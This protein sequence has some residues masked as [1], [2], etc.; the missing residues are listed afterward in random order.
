MELDLEQLNELIAVVDSG[1]VSAAAR[2]L[3]VP[4]STLSRRLT[5]LEA[6]LEVRLLHRKSRSLALTEAGELL[7]SRAR[8]L[9]DEAQETWRAV[10]NLAASPSGPLRLSVPPD[11]VFN[12]LLVSFAKAY[13]EI[14]LTAF[15]TSRQV[16]MVS[17]RID[18]AVRY[19]NISDDSLIARRL[20]T[21]TSSL[22]AAP[23]YLEHRGHPKSSANL[24]DHDCILSVDVNVHPIRTWRRRD[25]GKVVVRQRFSFNDMF[26]LLY[27]AVDALGIAMLPHPVAEPYVKSGQLEPVLAE[28]M[29][30]PLLCNLIYP[31]RQFVLPQVRTFID[32]AL[33]Y[34][35]SERDAAQSAFPPVQRASTADTLMQG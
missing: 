14:D 6:A 22:F 4:R 2:Q 12:H 33:A 29:G 5:E 3:G 13:P 15:A 34:Y 35:R 18:V 17:E 32:Y 9:L 24:R 1:S 21:V 16:D 20:W 30:F 23:A 27:A 28:E 31:D 11:P 26:G 8:T 19:G 10:K 25:G 7:V